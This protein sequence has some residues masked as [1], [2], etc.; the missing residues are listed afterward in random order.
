MLTLND[1]ESAAQRLRGYA[2]TTPLLR[3]HNDTVEIFVKAECLQRTGSF[4]FRGAYNAISLLS[5][6]A[7]DNGVVACSSGNHA[8][9]VALAASLHGTTSTIVMPNDAPRAKIANTRKLGAK[10]ILYDRDHENREEI[11]RALAEQTGAALIWPYDDYHVM[12]GQGTV[13]LELLQQGSSQGAQFDA[14]LVP[15]SGGGLAAGVSTVVAALAPTCAVYCIEPQG[16]DDHARSLASGRR[17]VNKTSSG[18][19]CDALLAPT[20]GELTFPINQTNLAG[21]FVVTDQQVHDAIRFAFTELKLVLEP[22][23]AIALAAALNNHAL[24][25]KSVCIIASGGNIDP[26]DFGQIIS[27]NSEC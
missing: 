3:T 15:C 8:Q 16:F 25:G 27:N 26:E 13:A 21:S 1:I 11:A 24:T 6:I 18:S 22:G 9:G 7:R 12:A 2:T 10:V 23:G 19:I 5:P 4:K 20:P 14:V 17:E